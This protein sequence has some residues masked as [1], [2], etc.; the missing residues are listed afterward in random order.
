MKRNPCKLYPFCLKCVQMTSRKVKSRRGS[1][2]R[3]TIRR[4]NGLISV[5][6]RLYNI[7]FYIWWDRND[8]V[9]PNTPLVWVPAGHLG[10]GFDNN[11]GQCQGQ[12]CPSAWA[13]QVCACGETATQ[14]GA[15]FTDWYFDHCRTCGWNGRP[16]NLIDGQHRIRGMA[17]RITDSGLPRYDE[18]IFVSVISSQGPGALNQMQAARMF[19]EING[20]IKRNLI[21]SY[22][23]YLVQHQ[24]L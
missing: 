20:G 2:N 10:M 18:P 13:L 23:M 6:I 5:C 7:T 8:T 21:A 19:I 22:L 15:Q 1:G 4:V 16:A 3:P 11:Q 9:S 12:I 14:Y 24:V 17:N